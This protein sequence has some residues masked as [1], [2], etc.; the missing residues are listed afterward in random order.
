MT[1]EE[2]EREYLAFCK[3]VD[4]AAMNIFGAAGNGRSEDAANMAA[5]LAQ[6][7]LTQANQY[8]MRKETQAGGYDL[9]ALKVDA[10][11]LTNSETA[12]ERED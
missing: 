1:F 7:A 8:R 3:Q 2:L 10:N 11:T 9:S 5:A 12:Y 6:R 4:D